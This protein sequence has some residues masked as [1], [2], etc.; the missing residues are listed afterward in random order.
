[1][2]GYSC[3]NS[4]LR[5]YDMAHNDDDKNKGLLSDPYDYKLVCFI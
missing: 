2:S 4:S 5:Q 1:M 3:P